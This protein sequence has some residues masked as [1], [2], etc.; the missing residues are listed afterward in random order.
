[1]FPVFFPPNLIAEPAKIP[2]VPYGSAGRV[3][4]SI[5]RPVFDSIAN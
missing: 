1:M 3:T 4:L 2:I 5:I